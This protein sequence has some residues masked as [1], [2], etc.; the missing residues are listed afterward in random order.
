MPGMDGHEVLRRIKEHPEWRAT[1]VI[2]I[3][4]SQDMDGIIECIEAGAD[5]YVI[6]CHGKI[7]MQLF[8]PP[9]R[10]CAPRHFLHHRSG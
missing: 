10:K 5:D 3:S 8:L 6:E 4:G 2:V 9:R 7:R 1:P